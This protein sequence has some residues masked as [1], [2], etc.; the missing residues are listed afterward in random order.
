MTDNGNQILKN[1]KKKSKSAYHLFS[2]VCHKI[3]SH[4]DTYNKNA[5]SNSTLLITFSLKVDFLLM[6]LVTKFY[7]LLIVESFGISSNFPIWICN[8]AKNRGLERVGE[9]YRPTFLQFLASFH[10]LE[11]GSIVLDQFDQL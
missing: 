7:I 9:Y 10:L 3:K 5:S 1:W 6:S 8:L 11:I 4:Y 2:F